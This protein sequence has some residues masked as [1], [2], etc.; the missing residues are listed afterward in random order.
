MAMTSLSRLMECCELGYSDIG[1][2]G[3]DTE[4]QVNRA[5]SIESFLMALF[6]ENGCHNMLGVDIYNASYGGTNALFNALS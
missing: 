4:S 5:K 6:E 1:R 3:V 2:L